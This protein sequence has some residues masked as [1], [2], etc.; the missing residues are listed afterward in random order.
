MLRAY[1]DLVKET[2][3]Q[4][5]GPSKAARKDGLGIDV[6]GL[7]EFESAISAPI[8]TMPRSYL[9]LN[10]GSKTL[11]KQTFKKL[12]FKYFCDV[13]QEVKTQ[14]AKEIDEALG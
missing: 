3:K 4:P 12:A 7:D 13:R 2:M 8:W 5:A 11:V 9:E 10:I 14:I 1:G 6:S